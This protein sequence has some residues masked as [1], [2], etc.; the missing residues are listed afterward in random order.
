[1]TQVILDPVNSDIAMVKLAREIAMDIQPLQNILQQ[2]AIS[3]ETWSQLQSNTRFQ[4]L[5]SSEIE[6][7]QTALNTHERVKMK[8][9][10]M[11][12]E[13]LPNLNMRMHDHEEALPAVIEAGKMLARIANLGVP[14]DVTAGNI[15]ERFVINISMG[16]AAQPLEFSKDVTPQVTIE[17]EPSPEPARADSAWG[18]VKGKEK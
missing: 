6:A 18:G 5:L 16:P 1:M 11:L 4:M 9:A 3:D 7:W 12:E 17:H 10:A 14:G 8:S 2:Y 15:G 13:W